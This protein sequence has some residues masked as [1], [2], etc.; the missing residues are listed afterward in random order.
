MESFQLENSWEFCNPTNMLHT[1]IY[2]SMFKDESHTEIISFDKKEKNISLRNG[3][4]ND[5]LKYFC[6]KVMEFS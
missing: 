5:K 1:C 3:A 2:I 6:L 4:K